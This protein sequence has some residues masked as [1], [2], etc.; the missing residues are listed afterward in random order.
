MKKTAIFY[1]FNTHKTSKIAVSIKE[2]FRD[3]S[4]E[5]VNV[6]DLDSE[7]FLKY[8]NY[9]LGVPTWFDGELPNY[10]DEFIPDLEDLDLK[11]KVFAIYG[12]GDQKKYS[13]NFV[14]GIGLMAEIL[15]EKGA[16]LVGYTSIEGYT[17]E[18][19]KAIRGD[20]FL[21]LAIDYENQG[22]MNK[23]RVKNWVDDLKKE[24][25]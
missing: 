23:E 22:S 1:S 12:L 15:L 6:E 10:W 2:S 7:N 9:V 3:D 11:G 18:A 17:F 20:Q 4:I 5:L 8:D 16:K 21:G 25:S 13:E 19:S 14:D 24:F